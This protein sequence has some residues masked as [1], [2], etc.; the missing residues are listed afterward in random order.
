MPRHI[1]R[2]TP[3]IKAL[4]KS[5][6]RLNFE[7]IFLYAPLS[8][9]QHDAAHLNTRQVRKALDHPPIKRSEDGLAVVTDINE[10]SS[11]RRCVVKI[12][13]ISR[14]EHHA[15]PRRRPT[16]IKQTLINPNHQLV[17]RNDL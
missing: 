13:H 10:K 7:I 1:P 9:T 15:L 4:A 17:E 16:Y 14:G 3:Q 12:Q 11:N 8:E 2:C 6:G 5:F